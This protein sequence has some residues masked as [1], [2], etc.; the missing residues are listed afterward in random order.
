MDS[1]SFLAPHSSSFPHTQA[2]GV[3]RHH[4]QVVRL[5]YVLLPASA[6]ADALYQQICLAPHAGRSL[7]LSWAPYTSSLRGAAYDQDVFEGCPVPFPAPPRISAHL[8]H[9]PPCPFPVSSALSGAALIFHSSPSPPLLYAA[10]RRATLR[11]QGETHYR[12][13][14]FSTQPSSPASLP[15]CESAR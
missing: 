10:P 6:H 8:H 1:Q 5:P 7:I 9:R 12:A 14:S 11:P 4:I 13:A 2:G 15:H 3:R